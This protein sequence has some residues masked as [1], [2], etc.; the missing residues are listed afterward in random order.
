Q[1]WPVG[2]RQRRAGVSSFGISGTNAHV[3]LEEAPHDAAPNGSG[4]PAVTDEPSVLPFVLSAKTAT[5]L[6]A[7]AERLRQWVASSAAGLADV[8][9]ALADSRAGLE[10]RAAVIAADRVELERGLAVLAAGE[11]SGS[12]V[13]GQARRSGRLGFLFSG[14]GSQRPGMG[15]QLHGR[16]P[17]FA[18][19]FDEACGLLDERLATWLGESVSVCDVTWGEDAERVEQTVFAQ[20]GLFAFEVAL[21]RLLESLGVRPSV[22]AGHSIGEIVAAHVAGVLSLPD[23]C[24]LVAARGGLMQRLPQG[25]AMVA[26]AASEADVASLLGHGVGIAAIN[27]PRSIVLSGADEQVSA[28]AAEMAE[29]GCKT[30]R[31]KVSHAF[32]SALM[33]PMLGEFTRVVDGLDFDVPQLTAISTVTGELVDRQWSSPRYWVDQVRSPV[34]FADAVSTMVADG[35]STFLEI[36]PGAALSA[37]GPDCV[38]DAD[39]AFVPV[40]RSN[41][42]E[43]QGIAKAI[44][45]LF[46]RGVRADWPRVFGGRRQ[47]VD[48]PTYAFQHERFW[49]EATPQT[50][51]A[52]GLGQT[53]VGHPLLGAVVA[54]PDDAVVLT[55]RLRLTSQSWLA[56]HAVL[57]TVL[58]PGTGL[59]EMALQAGAHASCARLAELT[60]H[61]PLL[62]PEIGGVQVRVTVAPARESGQRSVVI[63]SRTENDDR[64]TPWTLHA[65][66]S[67]LAADDAE[68]EVPGFADLLEWPPRDAVA[69]DL[70]GAYETL[71]DNGYT[72]G[73]TFRGLRQAWQRGTELFAEVQLTEQ[74]FADAA[75]FELHPA[76]LDSALHAILLSWGVGGQQQMLLPYAWRGVSLRSTG[77]SGLRVRLSPS[78]ENTVSV[79]A[80]DESGTPVLAVDSLHT[81]PVRVEQLAAAERDSRDPMYRVDWQPIAVSSTESA[82]RV[83]EWDQRDEVTTGT[84]VYWENRKAAGDTPDAVRHATNDA[85]AVLQEWI[86]D[87]RYAE[88]VLVLVTR[89]AIASTDTEVPELPDAA[90]LGLARSA[91]AEAAGRIIV[92]DVNSDADPMAA[93]GAAAF[94][95]RPELSY[96]DGVYAAPRLIRVPESADADRPVFTADGTVLITGG[97]GGLGAAAARHLVCAH[98][99]RNLLLVSRSGPAAAGA[100]ELRAELVGLGATV[101]IEQCDVSDRADLARVL[102]GIPAARPLSGVV[103]AAG[104]IDDGLIGSLDPDRLATV[105][106]PKADAAWYLHELTKDRPLSAFVL[107]SSLAGVAGGGGQGNYAA[108]NSVLGALAAQRKAQGLPAI[109]LAW[110]LWDLG[111]GEGLTDQGSKRMARIGVG[112]LAPAQGLA[113]MDAA[114]R[115][116][117]DVV[118]LAKFERTALESAGAMIPPL[119][120]SLTGGTAKA[121]RDAGALRRQLANMS[122]DQQHGVVLKVVRTAAA[123]I[124]GHGS[125]DEIEHDRAFNELGFDSLTSVEFR[126]ALNG[127]TGLQ[128]SAT[129]AFDYPTPTALAKHIVDS[130]GIEKVDNTSLLIKD[131]DRLGASV[132]TMLTDERERIKVIKHLEVLIDRW[133]D[134][135]GLIEENGRITD[136]SDASDDELFAAL[137]DELDIP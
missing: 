122:P 4:E 68:P 29:R 52:A 105:L 39:V 19:A 53:A 23:A 11:D 64:D 50:G 15:R 60:L 130:M 17:A 110:G 83:L 120:R 55:G 57:G 7:Q 37:M 137:D 2:E 119:L 16:F 44:G 48:L 25:G 118:V 32:H 89:N 94:A 12:V 20:A 99:V 51:D 78:G 33:E 109:S 111:M 61:A 112:A 35:A 133:R 54:L 98:G 30:T 124:L 6:A 3:I 22:V 123:T 28:V 69:M 96:R 36:G 84:V 126:N 70:D 114:L 9:V 113:M 108:A 76:L 14:Q 107:F 125:A 103:H 90:V 87:E 100:E 40:V 56:D 128:L 62:I 66:G 77:A 38:A 127:A 86:S 91:Q 85:L 74:A 95:G 117:T 59:V 42:E 46:T 67:L 21:F 72:Y 71:A 41:D 101:D 80:A 115:L 131:I 18:R 34:R 1:P 92:L 97:T 81:R 73:P 82:V 24:T 31:L 13:R 5:G 134:S 121:G 104:V 93:V 8:A 63:H 132:S 102:D 135:D 79:L 88:S 45:R 65:E 27:G 47:V 106:R 116:D 136:Y 75:R 43:T 26:V 129:M 49:L 58:V 10:H